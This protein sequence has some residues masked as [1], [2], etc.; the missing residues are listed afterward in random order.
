MKIYK[1]FKIIYTSGEEET[2]LIDGGVEFFKI[3]SKFQENKPFVWL[4]GKFINRNEIQS[5]EPIK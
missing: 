5:V 1:G 2:I 3:E 4:D